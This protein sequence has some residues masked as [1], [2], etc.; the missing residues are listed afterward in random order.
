[1]LD[2]TALFESMAQVSDLSQ[3]KTMTTKIPTATSMVAM[4]YPA[5]SPLVMILSHLHAK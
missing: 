1:M 5:A 2:Y 3:A 4:I